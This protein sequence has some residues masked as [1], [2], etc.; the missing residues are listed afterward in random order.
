LLVFKLVLIEVK[1]WIAQELKK[2][3]KPKL[4]VVRDQKV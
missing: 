2:N 3:L 1:F 4:G